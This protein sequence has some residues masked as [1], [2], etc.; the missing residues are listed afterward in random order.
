MILDTEK[1]CDNYLHIN[2]PKARRVV[3]TLVEEENFVDVWRLMNDDTRKYTWRRLNPTKKQAILD[4][5][6][7]SEPIFSFVTDSDIVPGYRTDHS[8]IILKL[9]LQELE[10]GRSYWKFNNTLLKD[11]KYI[12]EVKKIISEVKSIYATNSETIN[13]NDTLDNEI[14][15][16]INDQLFLETL[17]MTIRG[18]TIKY[19]S[20]EKRKKLEE[21]NKLE[22]EINELEEIINNDF[23][24]ADEDKIVNLARKKETFIEIRKEKNEGVMLRSR[25]RYQDLGE[26][27]SKYFFNL[28]NRNYANK[29]MTKII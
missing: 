29:A 25:S 8:G 26:K 22:Q 21:E 27:P 14:V 20:V 19:S 5:F 4:Y 2:N 1:D 3:L 15:F 18:N 28:E 10:R 9:K 16:N 13:V 11:K 7:V 6:L 24:N 12:E 17:L 23:S